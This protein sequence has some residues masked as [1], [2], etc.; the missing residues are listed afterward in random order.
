MNYVNKKH[1]WENKQTTFQCK[2]FVLNQASKALSHLVLFILMDAIRCAVS[3]HRIFYSS[4][5][6][7][8]TEKHVDLT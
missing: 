1:C 6:W 2:I 4:D 5:F 3:F 8:L 7:I